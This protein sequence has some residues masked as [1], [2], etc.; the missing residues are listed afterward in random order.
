LTNTTFRII[1]II[2]LSYL[3]DNHDSS[4]RQLTEQELEDL[5]DD[6]SSDLSAIF[7]GRSE[8]PL[9][10]TPFDAASEVDVDEQ[11]FVVYQ[12]ICSGY[13]L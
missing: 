2:I 5:W 13:L 9:D 7:Q 12:I 3:S 1:S 4:P 10:V 6:V 11:R 8:L